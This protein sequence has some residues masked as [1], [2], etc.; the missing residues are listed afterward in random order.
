[1][2][3]CILLS[4][5][6]WFGINGSSKCDISMLHSISEGDLYTCMCIKMASQEIHLELLQVELLRNLKYVWH[7]SKSFGAISIGLCV[8]PLY[9]S[10][11]N[12]ILSIIRK[13][14]LIH[15][16]WLR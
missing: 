13:K 3:T 14:T 8:K 5:S 15:G 1:M 2:Y 12:I 16:T 6:P 4:L 11:H 10:H 7:H 9:Q